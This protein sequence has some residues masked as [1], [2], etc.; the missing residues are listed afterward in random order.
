MAS[1]TSRRVLTYSTI[2]VEGEYVTA[3]FHTGTSASRHDVCHMFQG[4]F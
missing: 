2:I 3:L 1:R 4:S